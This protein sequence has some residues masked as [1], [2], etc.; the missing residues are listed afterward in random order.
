MS[1]LRALLI[2][3]RLF[4]MALFAGFVIWCALSLRWDW[5]PQ[6]LPLAL[7]GLWRTIWIL[8]VTVVLIL[9]REK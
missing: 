6:Y 1:D 7:E 9:R 8:V 2:P 4:L 5:L 3:R